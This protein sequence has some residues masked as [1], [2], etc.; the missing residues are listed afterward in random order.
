MVFTHYTE[1]DKIVGRCCLAFQLHQ[2]AQPE[3][4]AGLSCAGPGL[5]SRG[6]TPTITLSSEEVPGP[7][8]DLSSTAGPCHMGVS[9]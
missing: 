5:G 2:A 7:C 3:G 1:C 9:D 8:M 6:L 4:Q